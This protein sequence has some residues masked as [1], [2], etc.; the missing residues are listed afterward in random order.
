MQQV[1]PGGHQDE[2]GNESTIERVG[3]PDGNDDRQQGDGQDGRPVDGSAGS[4]SWFVIGLREDDPRNHVRNN[5]GSACEERDDEAKSS[6]DRV[7]VEVLCEPAG[8]APDLAVG[9]SL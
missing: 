5:A 7:D 3:N 4:W 1:E 2:C 8:H 9:T 6:N